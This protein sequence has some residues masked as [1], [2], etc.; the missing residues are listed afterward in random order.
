MKQQHSVVYEELLTFYWIKY[1]VL[2]FYYTSWGG[3][4]KITHIFK[5]LCLAVFLIPFIKKLH[6]QEN[7]VGLKEGNSKVWIISVYM[8]NLSANIDV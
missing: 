4:Q 8:Y 7:Y 3:N 2:V 6:S 1:N 5:K